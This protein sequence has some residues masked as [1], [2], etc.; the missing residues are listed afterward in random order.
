MNLYM[1]YQLMNLSEM[2]LDE[3][4]THKESINKKWLSIIIE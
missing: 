1:I 4:I 3:Y 2:K